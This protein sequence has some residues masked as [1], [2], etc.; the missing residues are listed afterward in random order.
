MC[1]SQLESKGRA[2]PGKDD[3]SWTRTRKH[4]RRDQSGRNSRTTTCRQTRCH[5]DGPSRKEPR[6]GKR[7]QHLQASPHC[8]TLLHAGPRHN[9]HK[10][11]TS[12]PRIPHELRPESPALLP[13]GSAHLRQQPY[14]R[15]MSVEPLPPKFLPQQPLTA[16]KGSRPGCQNAIQF[17]LKVIL[18]Q[19]R[20]V[21]TRLWPGHNSPQL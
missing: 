17:T 9:P 4:W 10:H 8:S 7:A 3:R 16:S 12:T 5:R 19:R 6:P 2:W 15:R 20:L 13:C 1:F 14:L 18:P 21:G 11:L